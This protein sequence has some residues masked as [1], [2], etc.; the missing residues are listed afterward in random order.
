MSPALAMG[1]CLLYGEGCGCEVW[2]CGGRSTEGTGD[3]PTDEAN[4]GRAPPHHGRTSALWCL[5]GASEEGHVT[6]HGRRVPSWRQ[7]SCCAGCKVSMGAA[8]SR[9]AGVPQHTGVPAQGDAAPTQLTSPLAMSHRPGC[10]PKTMAEY[11]FAPGE[12][13]A[14]HTPKIQRTCPRVARKGGQLQGQR[15]GRLRW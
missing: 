15:R 4:I 3:Q 8:S 13:S 6:L 10:V 12:T 11:Q 5:S 7:H 14:T 2:I 9:G 1:P